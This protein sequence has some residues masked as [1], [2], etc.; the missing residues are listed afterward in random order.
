M[1]PWTGDQREARPLPPQDSTTQKDEDNIHTLSRIW[2]HCPNIQA[3]K[4]HA[5]DRVATVIFHM[6]CPQINVD[7]LYEKVA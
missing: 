1:T 2:I 3:V 4:T 7:N 5:L 6:L